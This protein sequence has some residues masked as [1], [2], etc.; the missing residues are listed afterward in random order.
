MKPFF[1]T[2]QK[3]FRLQPHLWSAIIALFAIVGLLQISIVKTDRH[4]TKTQRGL[5]SLRLT[6]QLHT[7]S[8]NRELS[9]LRFTDSLLS[10]KSNR[11]DIAKS[12][13]DLKRTILQTNEKPR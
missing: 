9:R 6:S 13:S 2:L 1:E 7:D 4:L 12:L 11:V 3:Q 8:I 5:D 10:V